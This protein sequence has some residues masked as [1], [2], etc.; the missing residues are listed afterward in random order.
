[1]SKGRYADYRDD[2]NIDALEAAIGFDVLRQD[3]ANDIGYCVFPQNHSNGDT[4]G[5]FAIHRDKKVYGCFVCGGGSLLS[6]AMELYDFTVDEATHWLKQFAVT[7]TRSDAEYRE[8]LLA[9]LEDT[10]TRQATLPYFNPR[11]LDRF[12]D[13]LWYFYDRGISHKVAAAYHLRYTDNTLKSAPMKQKDGETTKIDDDYYGPAAIFPHFWQGRLVGWQHRWMEFPEHTPKWLA[14]YTNTT[15]F[16]K[17]TTLYNYDEAVKATRPIVVVESVPTVLYLAT[18]DIPAVSFFGSEPKPEQ[19]R[20]MRRFKHGVIL[21]PDNDEVG[22][23]M[24]RKTTAYLEPFIPV[25]HAE[26][27]TS[28]PG[29]DLGDY[30]KRPRGYHALHHH[31]ETRVH[32]S[33]DADSVL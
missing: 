22:D 21:A 19:L 11:V 5:K 15:D 12:A 16:P 14:K 13:P 26:K 32:P 1:M 9:L 6:L 29:A 23:K 31:L 25:W 28:A 10:E 17:S 18:H 8:Y 4:T 27:V 3:G 7:D 33:L 24:V 2:I 20:L 30:A